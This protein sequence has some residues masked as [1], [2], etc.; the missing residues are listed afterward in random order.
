MEIVEEL[1]GRPLNIE[2][3]KRLLYLKTDK[4]ELKELDDLKASRQELIESI[5][6]QK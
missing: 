2:E 6:K 3:I 4:I 5:D 1:G